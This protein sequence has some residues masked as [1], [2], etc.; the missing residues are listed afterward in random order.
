MTRRQTQSEHVA[1]WPLFQHY[2]VSDVSAASLDTL[3]TRM[4]S[5]TEGGPLLDDYYRS[6]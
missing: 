5:D 4:D 6:A 2:K 3:I 1:L